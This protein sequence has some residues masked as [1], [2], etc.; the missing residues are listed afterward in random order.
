M[1]IGPEEAIYSR[2][3]ENNTKLKLCTVYLIADSIDVLLPNQMA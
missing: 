3:F 1:V 2:Q